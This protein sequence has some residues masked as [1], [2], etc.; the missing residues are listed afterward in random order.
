MPN[1]NQV[2]KEIGE[3]SA[4]PIDIVRKKYLKQLHK[5]TGRN[6]IAYYSAFLQKTTPQAQALG[7]IR[8][9]DKNGF[10]NVIHGMDTS[11]GLDLLLHTPGGDIAAVESLVAYLRSKFT[12]IRAIVPQMAMSAGTMMACACDEIVMGKQSNLGPFDPQFGGIPA[13]GIIEEFNKAKSEILQNPA[14]VNYWGIIISK[15]HPTFIGECEKAIKWASEIVKGWLESGMFKDCVDKAEKA[16]LVVSSLNN[17]I[18]TLT[19][20]RHIHIDQIRDLGLKV[21][22]LEDDDKLQD[23]VLTVH[24][25]YMH[26]ISNPIVVKAIEN[27]NG[28]GMFWTVNE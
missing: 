25:A 7:I 2:L 21:T 28:H 11:K 15:Y 5:H 4:S 12:N 13:Y 9:D 19:H 8:D 20:S 17:H 6:V 10:M 3:A 26:T 16:E 24:H 1:W 27:H 14:A 22:A 18:G 23:L